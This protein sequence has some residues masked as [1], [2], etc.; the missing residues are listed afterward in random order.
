[1]END[2]LK[3]VVDGEG[4]AEREN[5]P[6]RPSK[7]P[8][9]LRTKKPLPTDRAK[10]DTQAAALRAFVTASNRG[11][12]AVGAADVAARISITEATAG[13]VNNFFVDAGFLT[14]EGKGKYKPVEAV[15]EYARLYTLKPDEAAK[16]LQEPLRKSWY[17]TEIVDE[18]QMG[19]VQEDVLVNVLARAAGA[20]GDRKAQLTLILDWLE[21]TKLI[22]RTDG[23]VTLAGADAST[24]G[25]D[26]TD[27]PN[28]GGELET[29]DDRAKGER[30]TKNER[31]GSP[32]TSP[33]VL[34][35]S[36]E[37]TLTAE[38]LRKLTPEQISAAF[39]A[40]GKVM[41]IKAGLE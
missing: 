23:T 3:I 29:P 37:F 24:G 32:A 27:P 20:G 11:L 39:E 33:Q 10:F 21:Y 9:R 19:S 31:G 35:F 38:D 7:Q 2:H 1:M 5:H 15:V 13:L 40:V 4:N 41:A 28:N 22:V 25:G 26:S 12:Q 30:T 34:G 16:H 6:E 36:F 8:A 18:L 17:F 14:K